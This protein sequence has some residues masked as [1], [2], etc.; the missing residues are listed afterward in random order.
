MARQSPKPPNAHSS[1]WAVGSL[2]PK[3]RLLT[4]AQF[5]EM[6]R[7]QADLEAKLQQMTAAGR[8]RRR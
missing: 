5:A 4:K 1:V 8:E 6:R 7:K 2:A 3:H